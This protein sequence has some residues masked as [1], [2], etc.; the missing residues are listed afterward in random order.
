MT[1]HV[2]CNAK[3]IV[4]SSG[5]TDPA[6]L[7]SELNNFSLTYSVPANEFRPLGAYYPVRGTSNSDWSLSLSGYFDQLDPGQNELS[8]GQEVFF[9]VW[10]LGD[11]LPLTDPLMRGTCYIDSLDTSGSPDDLLPLS[12]SS[13]GSSELEAINTFIGRT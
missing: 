6:I 5:P 2:G 8:A 11:D 4:K 13:T 12:I 7:V 3:I 9:E 10:P 1:V